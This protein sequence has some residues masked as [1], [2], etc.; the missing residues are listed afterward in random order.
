MAGAISRSQKRDDLFSSSG[1]NVGSSTA[2]AFAYQQSGEPVDTQQQR[3][4]VSSLRYH[5]RHESMEHSIFSHPSV[6]KLVDKSNRLEKL[7]NATRNTLG[8]Q[9]QQLERRCM[10]A[11]QVN[12]ALEKRLMRAM[13][14]NEMLSIHLT[15]AQKQPTE[16]NGKV[17]S[18]VS[19]NERGVDVYSKTRDIA[20]RVFG[21]QSVNISPKSQ[22]ARHPQGSSR[23]EN[24]VVEN[25]GRR[26]SDILVGALRTSKQDKN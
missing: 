26:M 11:S 12:I 25:L 2:A 10:S 14:E 22:Q 16:L 6:Q 5:G 23:I 8:D 19:V 21:R 13:Q 3:S 18:Q 7:L 24:G 9:V 17:S 15:R 4:S 1:K 20:P